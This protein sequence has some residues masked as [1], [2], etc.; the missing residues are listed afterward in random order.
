V[1]IEVRLKVDREDF[2]LDVE[3]HLP[4]S[5]VTALFGPSGCGKTTL[6]RAIAGLDRQTGCYLRVGNDIWQD[7]RSFLAP[8]L[9][10]LGY[11]FQEASLFEHLSVQGNL[12]YGVKRIPQTLQR[13]ALDEAI[14]LLQISQFLKRRPSSLSGGERQ[15]VAIARALAVSPKLLLMD[16]PLAALDSNRKQEII[17][18]LETLHRELDIPIIYVSHQVEEV[19][20]LADYLVLLESG[21]VAA[22]GDI[23]DVFTRLDLPLSHE[24]EAACLIEAVVSEHDDKYQL[25]HLEF[26]GGR[27][28]MAQM[29]LSTGSPVRL[30]LAARDVSLTLEHQ[31]GTSILN[32]LPVTVDALDSLDKARVI[33]RL[34]AEDVPLLACITR[35]SSDD[36]QLVPGQRLF[37][38][39]KSIALLT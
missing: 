25:T 23:H 30:R 37:A 6:L 1:T 27:I 20:R 7:D 33:V 18:Y 31:S 32:I 16:E 24:N 29:D 11:V 15:R 10:P 5:G 39:I 26:P 8:H 21:Q 13:I 19:S 36:L 22:C 12:E 34:L 9:R 35:K 2:R 14:E 3:L 17:P 28:T 4:S 38:Q